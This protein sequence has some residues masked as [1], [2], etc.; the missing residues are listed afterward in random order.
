MRKLE[1]LVGALAWTAISFAI[2]FTALEPFGV[3]HLQAAQELSAL[4]VD[5]P[6]TATMLCETSIL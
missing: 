6:A 2:M 5:W 1:L 3:Q 4:C